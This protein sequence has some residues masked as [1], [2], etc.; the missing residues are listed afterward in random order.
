MP[1][2]DVEKP[3]RFYKTASAEPQEAGFAVKLDHRSL[4]T[5]AGKPLT[6][7]SRALAEG[8]AAEW[9]AQLEE[10]DTG[11]MPLTRLAF[12]AIDRGSETRAELAAE[13]ARYAG[14]DVL[15]YRAEAPEALIEREAAEWDRWLDWAR[16]E[17]GI[18]LHTTQGIS[19]KPQPSASLERAEARALLFDD[20][21]LTGLVAATALLGSAV[22]ALA[23]AEGKIGGEGAL[24]V[25]TLDERFQVEQWG[26]DAEAAQ[27]TA[28]HQAEA[29][30]LEAWFRA[31][32]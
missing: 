15:C 7:A 4:K 31:L 22:L 20:L 26:L 32:V 29:R 9:E 27:R 21:G 3:R 12:T 25:A 6:L 28:A 11:A 10:I 23:L 24:D 17:H 19:H 14:S 1:A 8:I 30:S 2:P 5:P 18:A 16:H 13:F